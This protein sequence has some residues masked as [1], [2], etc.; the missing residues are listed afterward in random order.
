V[1]HE[2]E[3]E[4]FYATAYARLVRQL[5]AYTG[6]RQDAEDVVQEAFARASVRWGIVG[7][8]DLPEAWVRRVAMNLAISE[9]RRVKRSLA[10]LRR[11]GMP[12][13]AGEPS[14]ERSALLEALRKLPLKY[15][16]VLVLHYLA[17]LSV[18]EIARERG[19]PPGTVTTRL[20]RGR[21]AL[22][23]QLDA[24]QEDEEGRVHVL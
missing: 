6:S 22:G 11:L 16:E 9:L 23:R 8:L 7:R 2:D 18:Q 15:R 24:G 13:A 20:A 10:A 12:G 21:E 17:D 5:L 3:F 14:V 1:P 19:L 4:V